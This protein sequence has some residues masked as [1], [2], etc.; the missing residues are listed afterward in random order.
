LNKKTISTVL[1]TVT[2]LA[3]IAVIFFLLSSEPEKS[4]NEWQKSLGGDKNDE[5]LYVLSTEDKGC[6]VLGYTESISMGDRDIWLIKFDE[7]GEIQWDKKYGGKGRDYAKTVLKTEEGY[8]IAG[9]SNSTSSKNWDYDILLIKT[10]FN[11]T[12][13]WNYTYGGSDAEEANSILQ[14]E[15]GSYII[16]GS[17]SS[18]GTK[19]A[20]DLWIV[21][22]D[23]DG[24]HIWNRTFGNIGFDEGRS[25]IEVENGYVIAGKTKSHSNNTDYAD[26]WLL[27]VNKTGHHEWNY[28][29]GFENNDLFNQIIPSDNG[30]IMVGHTQNI[31]QEEQKNN[32]NGYI[33]KTDSDGKK[34][35]EKIVEEEKD[36]GISS[37]EKTSDGYIITGFIGNYG[38]DE[39]DLLIE[40][41][42]FYGNKIWMKTYGESYSDAGVWITQGYKNYY[43][44]IGYKDKIEV[45]KSD[46]WLLKFNADAVGE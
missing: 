43:Y 6:L 24:N 39:D 1:V 14:T 13:E 15:D 2:F 20:G 41:I 4:K 31:S 11:G 8:V 30:F 25:I 32:W 42:D 34:E 45:I 3:I 23:N 10:D 26:A 22:L 21:K 5:G 18:Y 28:T 40:K 33:V 37:I 44:V 12:Q 9:T 19:D 17:T 46:L 36:T 27:K 7:T 35:W 29:Y 16:T 38:M